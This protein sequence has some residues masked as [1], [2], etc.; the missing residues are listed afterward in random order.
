MG[1]GPVQGVGFRVAAALFFRSTSSLNQPKYQVSQTR[2]PEWRKADSHG[3]ILSGPREP[4]RFSG[5][6]VSGATSANPAGEGLRGHLTPQ[7]ARKP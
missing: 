3:R 5:F 4:E 1:S 7:E 2:N 6:G